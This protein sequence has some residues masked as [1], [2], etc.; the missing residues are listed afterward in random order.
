MNRV[1]GAPLGVKNFDGA[2]YGRHWH[3]G[4]AHRIDNYAASSLTPSMEA[5]AVVREFVSARPVSYAFK[6]LIMAVYC[7]S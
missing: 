4:K 5:T 2:R 6:D 3:T 1:A 7:R